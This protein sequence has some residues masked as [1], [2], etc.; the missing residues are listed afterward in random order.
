VYDLLYPRILAGALL[1]RPL[2]LRSEC[3]DPGALLGCHSILN[4]FE[5]L[6]MDLGIPVPDA[7]ELA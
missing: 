4:L 7:N 1:S 2:D 6:P 5:P 3:N